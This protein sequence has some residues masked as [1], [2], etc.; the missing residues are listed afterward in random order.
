MSTSINTIFV[1]LLVMSRFFPNAPTLDQINKSSKEQLVKSYSQLC[2]DFLKHPRFNGLDV[3]GQIEFFAAAQEANKEKLKRKLLGD[4]EIPMLFKLYRD[5]CK[6]DPNPHALDMFDVQA[7][8]QEFNQLFDGLPSEE[9]IKEVL[10]HI[11][12]KQITPVYGESNRLIGEIFTPGAR[13][14][15]AS[16]SSDPT[17]S[18]IPL[19]VQQAF[20]AAEDKYFRT[21]KGVDEFGILRAL[22]NYILKGGHPEGGSTITQQLAKNLIVGNDIA[23]TRK[24]REMLV[25]ERI[26]K[27]FNKDQI[28][29]AYLNIIYLGRSTWGV[30]LAA[31]TYFNKNLKDLS[32]AEAALLAGLTKGPSYYDPDSYKDNAVARRTYVVNE[33]VSAGF[34]PEATGA[35]ALKTPI[36]TEEPKK[37]TS[38]APYVVQTAK[39]LTQSQLNV[40]N[41]ENGDLRIHTGINIELQE[42][43]ES[44]LRNGLAN[45]E[46]SLGRNQWRGP[47]KNLSQKIEEIK[48]AQA[49]ENKPQIDLNSTGKSFRDMANRGAKPA[50]PQPVQ[51]AEKKIL[52]PPWQIALTRVSSPLPDLP[53]NVAVVLKADTFPPFVGLKNGK[54]SRLKIDNIRQVSLRYGDV[55]FVED[56]EDGSMALR[57]LPEVQGA[58]VV[59]NPDDGT[60]LALTGGFSYTFSRFNRAVYG[61]RQPGSAIK[62]FTY[63]AAFNAGYQ[64]NSLVSDTPI[65]FPRIEAGAQPWSPRNYDRT[66]EGVITV[67]RALEQSRN[68]ATAHIMK[69]VGLEPIRNLAKE[70][71]LYENPIPYY[72]FI[73]GAQP[74]TLLRMVTGYSMIANQGNIVSPQFL[75]EVT[76]K[77]N[78]KLFNVNQV[79]TGNW[80]RQLQNADRE[81]L[82]QVR[83]VM[84]G[85]FARGTA[86]AYKDLADY[87]A[88]KTGTTDSAKDVWFVGFTNNLTVGVWVGYDNAPGSRARTLGEHGTGAKIALPI[89]NEIIRKSFQTYAPMSKFPEPPSTLELQPV[90]LRTGAVTSH[91]SQSSVLEALRAPYVGQKNIDEIPAGFE[92]A[93]QVPREEFAD[94]IPRPDEE[95][96]LPFVE[97]PEIVEPPRE[98]PKFRLPPEEDEEN[99][100]QLFNKEDEEE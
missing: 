63:I 100:D 86:Y 94:D 33:M 36:A 68:L 54:V 29:Q 99:W 3:N 61:Y 30:K 75:T 66:T 24:F 60:V 74:T 47:I 4:I 2:L 71:G 52:P 88:G 64:P 38:I 53:W 17:K 78:R 43:S 18:E 39:E 44:A 40:K 26:E 50:A 69:A 77:S 59:M 12:D 34:I 97:E 82:Y 16:L 32:V 62:P 85:V 84:Q 93:P 8:V 72:P 1:A 21:H 91:V 19:L 6:P 56:L 31:Q 58:V 80:N 98:Q 13:R 15:W 20:I 28:L 96:V 70:M 35:S 5:I 7:A 87:V 67:R 46:K 9:K 92:S 22:L 90:D 10:S 41:I 79:L 95:P 83:S 48:K 23:L 73:L 55:I 51:Q 89:F 76:D 81:S 14:L 45:F 42:I 27:N 65:W 11:Q 57:Q 25:A 37:V 49:E